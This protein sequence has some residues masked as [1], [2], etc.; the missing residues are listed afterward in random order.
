MILVLNAGSSS[1]KFSLYVD[2]ASG[3]VHRR[4]QVEELLGAA[5]FVARDG[6]GAIVAERRWD[7]GTPGHAPLGHDG[8]IAFLIDWLRQD[9]GRELR[10]CG[11]RVV[12]GGRDFARPVR[13]GPEILD[14]MQALAPLAPLHQPHNLAC[15]RAVERAMPGLPQV[16]CFDTAFHRT[17]PP[18][19]Q[20]FA[21]PRALTEAGILR[22]GFHG[23]SY[24]YIAEALADAAPALA[25]GRTVVAHLGNGASLCAMRAGR[26][27]ATTMGFTP[28]DGLMM[29]TRS[30]A[31][32]PG[33]IFHLALRHARKRLV[34]VQDLDVA[35]EPAA[36][37][38][39]E[40]AP[41]AALDRGLAGH[42]GLDLDHADIPEPGVV[43]RLAAQL[44]QV[45]D[46]EVVACLAAEVGADADHEVLLAPRRLGRLGLARLRH[47]FLVECLQALAHRQ[48]VRLGART[49]AE[50]QRQDQRQGAAQAKGRTKHGRGAARSAGLSCRPAAPPGPG[51]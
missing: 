42:R 18:E 38:G 37:V 34:R 3:A 5:R 10:A 4:G 41:D 16:A 48:L 46:L 6:Q 36:A 49:G 8:A 7:G 25:G 21:L 44:L 32:D 19:A 17:Q 26:S 14:K 51:S 33:V 28:L 43:G 1:L 13:I 22:Y 15:I 31:I 9:G 47:P 27:V 50:P 12:H 39:D 23:L 20:H 11:H 24:E 35:G 40:T 29:G 2:D 45:G 30:G